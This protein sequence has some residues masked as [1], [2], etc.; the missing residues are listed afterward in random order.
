MHNWCISRPF[1]CT[2]NYDLRERT[3]FA[4]VTWESAYISLSNNYW[5]MQ[6]ESAPDSTISNSLAFGHWLLR[7]LK[8]IQEIFLVRKVLLSWDTNVIHRDQCLEWI[9]THWDFCIKEQTIWA[10]DNCSMNVWNFRTRWKWT[11][12]HWVK[13]LRSKNNRLRSIITQLN[14][15]LLDPANLFY[16]KKYSKLTSRHHYCISDLKNFIQII[17]SILIF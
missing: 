9:F 15:V 6:V 10:V 17:D 5:C 3:I 8:H 14:N 2:N 13:E 1:W 11:K 12:N 16:W 7:V 4:Y